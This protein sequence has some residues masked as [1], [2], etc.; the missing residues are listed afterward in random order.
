[1]PPTFQEPLMKH[2]LNALALAVTAASLV[3]GTTA[4]AESYDPDPG[5]SCYW[6]SSPG[7][8]EFRRD[9]GTIYIPRDAKIGSVIGKIDMEAYTPDLARLSAACANDGTALLEFRATATAPIH[10]G[11]LEPINGEDI[12]GKV[13]KTNIS[14]VG[15]RVKL[16]HPYSGGC[17]NCFTPVDGNP[18]VPFLAL[19]EYNNL[20]VP[21]SIVGLRNFITLVK[22]GPIPPGPNVLDGSELWSGSLTALGKVMRYGVT[23][24][25]I[26]AQ[27]T[28]GAPSSAAPV[29]LG[30]WDRAEFTGPGFTTTK[31]PFHIALSN[32][33]TDTGAGFIATAH[34]Q[35]DGVDGSAPVGPVNSGVFSLTTD[36]QARGMGIQV[37]KAD[38]STPMEL[39]TE[40]PLIA[41][42]PG[43]MSLN[44]YARFYQTE[45]SSEVRPGKAKGALSFTL[46]YK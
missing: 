35:L 41:I 3:H 12:N 10:S 21:I 30:D 4:M 13:L 37:L 43:N 14:G 17:N 5:D 16:E 2:V 20:L 22:I 39:Q 1:M 9:I 19:N 11:G 33:E 27:C 6:L 26:Q 24:T 15:I 45:A 31:V 36:S 7:M 23:G 40:V 42:T 8:K 18:V 34:V 28:V 38:G 32:C 46:T 25:V 29:Q 44:F